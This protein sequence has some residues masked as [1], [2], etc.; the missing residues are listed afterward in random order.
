M[1]LWNNFPKNQN[2][3]SYSNII[4]INI[5]T[6]YIYLK[7]FLSLNNEDSTNYFFVKGN[8]TWKIGNKFIGQKY[9]NYIFKS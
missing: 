4:N 9:I 8:D 3:I 6:F 5:G 7:E 1:D 2:T